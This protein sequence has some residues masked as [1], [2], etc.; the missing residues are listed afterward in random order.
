MIGHPFRR[1]GRFAPSDMF[2]ENRLFAMEADEIDLDD[3]DNN[4]DMDNVLD[5]AIHTKTSI[6]NDSNDSNDSNECV[7]FSERSP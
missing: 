6:A 2:F 4:I 1:T 3:I 5:R 7:G